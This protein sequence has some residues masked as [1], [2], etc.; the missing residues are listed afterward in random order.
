MESGG[1]T[2]GERMLRS[3]QMVEFTPQ[4]LHCITQRLTTEAPTY[5][6]SSKNPASDIGHLFDFVHQVKKLKV[7]QISVNLVIVLH[8]LTFM[9]FCFRFNRLLGI[10]PMRLWLVQ[11]EALSLICLFSS[12]WKFLLYVNI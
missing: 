10:L 12:H 9:Y 5:D 6:T 7:V 8:E 3:D 2:L 4:Q 11:K 1:C